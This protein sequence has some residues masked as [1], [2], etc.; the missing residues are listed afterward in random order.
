[1]ATRMGLAQLRCQST[2]GSEHHYCVAHNVFEK[3]PAWHPTLGMFGVDRAAI[4]ACNEDE[5]QLASGL[6]SNDAKAHVR[7][8][9]D[10][11]QSWAP[12]RGIFFISIKFRCFFCIVL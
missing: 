8:A 7:F 2:S 9:G 6:P 3:E 10:T 1:M 11:V 12:N 4:S 5:W